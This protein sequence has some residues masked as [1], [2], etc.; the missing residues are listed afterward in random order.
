M[1]FAAEAGLPLWHSDQGLS[2][3]EDEVPNQQKNLSGETIIVAAIANQPSVLYW[4]STDAKNLFG[5]HPD[6]ENALATLKEKIIKLKAN[7][8]MM[9]GYRDLIIGRDPD[10]ACTPYQV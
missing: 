6:D 4:N 5:S 9:D 8:Q 3:I 1:R 2:D 7:N 10:N